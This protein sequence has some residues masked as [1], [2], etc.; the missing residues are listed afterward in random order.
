MEEQLNDPVLQKVRSWIKKSDKRPAKTHDI[1]QSKALLSYFNRFEQLFIDE[2]TN[3][4]C[5]N[6]TV[7]ETNKTEMKICVPL[8]LF[9][10]L[11]KLA[12]THSHG[13][14]P[15]IFK[16]FENVRQYF[17]WP[18]RYKWIVYLIE[19]CIECQTNKSKRHDLHEAPLEQWGNLK[20]HLLKQF[21]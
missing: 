12:H 4:L 16:I 9:L 13:G 20:L 8:S 21:I 3:F 6:E 1:N 10:P 14:H 19:D 2:E 17:F 7:Q 18:G 11:F 15:G 5:Y